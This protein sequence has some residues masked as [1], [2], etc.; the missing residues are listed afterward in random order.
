[1]ASV[2]AQTAADTS[3][4]DAYITALAANLGI[5]EAVLRDALKETNLARV[6]ARLAVGEITQAE[7]DAMT[8]R[9]NSGEAPL[10]GGGRGGDH[11]GH[12]GPGGVAGADLATFLGIDEAALR[13]ELQGGATLAQAAEAHGKSRDELK[14]F[15]TSEHDAHLAEEVAEGDLTAEQAAARATDFATGLDARIDSAK[16]AGGHGPRHGGR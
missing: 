10:L 14:A 15:L 16:G 1:M 5:D 7:A 3:R 11:G 8:A 2:A 12:G 6:A 4:A 13:T 9:I